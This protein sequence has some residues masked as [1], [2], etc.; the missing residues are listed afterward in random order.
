MAKSS[1]S[2]DFNDIL[3]DKEETKRFCDWFWGGQKGNE[4]ILALNLNN[5]KSSGSKIRRRYKCWPHIYCV[6]YNDDANPGKVRDPTQDKPIQWK[7]CKVGIT[8]IDTTTGTKNRMETIETKIMNATGKN[9]STIFVLPVKATD[10]RPNK[11]IEKSVREHVGW[12]VDEDLARSNNFPVIT[13]WVLTTQ[14]YIKDI[15]DMIDKKSV[16]DTGLVL[17]MSKFNQNETYL[18][19]KLLKLPNGKVGKRGQ[20]T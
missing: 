3:S 6:V 20:S 18:P 16:C 5:S 8:E 15:R 13:E 7:Y 14:D 12:S 2:Y 10:S 19:R 11:E 17:D 4:L 9:A 1:S